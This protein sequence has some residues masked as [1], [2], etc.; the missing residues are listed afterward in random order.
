LSRIRELIQWEHAGLLLPLRTQAGG[1]TETRVACVAGLLAQLHQL[2]TN[3]P[4]ALE[5]ALVEAT[6]GD[7]RNSLSKEWESV[8]QRSRG[9]FE[10]FTLGLIREDL[11]FFFSHAMKEDKRAAFWLKYLGSIRRTICVLD[12][13]T[14]KE[15]NN[16]AKALDENA[17]LAARRAL[18][19]Y[20][21]GVSAFCLVFDSWVAIEFSI[22]GNATYIYSRARFEDTVLPQART[23][24]RLGQLKQQDVAH[25]RLSH[26]GDW[27]QPFSNE[28]WQLGIKADSL[29]QWMER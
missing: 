27:E 25:K 4:P 17:Q 16:A 9:G 21:T 24:P 1:S 6:F 2:R 10:S 8:R 13:K 3:V 28:L 5:A 7:P 20:E 18:P 23:R 11:R 26:R 15:V 14:L 22:S 12:P 29:R 19:M